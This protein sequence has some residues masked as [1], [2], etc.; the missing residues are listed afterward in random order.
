M[1]QI[2]PGTFSY[3]KRPVFV[4]WPAGDGNWHV[5]GPESEL[6][7]GTLARVYKHSTQEIEDVEIIDHVAERMVLRRSGERVRFVLTTFDAVMDE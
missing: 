5:W 1:E 7:E 6:A 4:R 3:D 2:G